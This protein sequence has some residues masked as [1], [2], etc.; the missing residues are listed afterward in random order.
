MRYIIQLPERQAGRT[1]RQLYFWLPVDGRATEASE[2]WC[3][4]QLAAAKFKSRKE[5]HDAARTFGLRNYQVIEMEA[6][7]AQSC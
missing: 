3:F 4:S 7:R 6:D 2:R 5:A 1:E